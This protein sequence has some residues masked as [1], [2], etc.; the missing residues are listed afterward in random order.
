MTTMGADTG[1]GQHTQLKDTKYTKRGG[2]RARLA[3]PPPPADARRFL[4]PEGAVGGAS[5][6]ASAAGALAAG[7]LVDDGFGLTCIH[8]WIGLRM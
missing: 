3:A 2:H 1:L 4:A 8:K 6:S 7:P 5:L